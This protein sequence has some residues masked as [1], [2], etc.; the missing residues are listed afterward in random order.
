[1]LN[2]LKAELTRKGLN[3]VAEIVTTINCTEKT[4]RNKLQGITPFT[5]PEAIQVREKYFKSEN[6]KFEY[7]FEERANENGCA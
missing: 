1:M 2:N 4:A 6:F 3:P 7:L 5:V